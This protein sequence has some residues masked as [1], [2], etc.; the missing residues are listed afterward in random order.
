MLRTASKGSGPEAPAWTPDVEINGLRA[1]ASE[2]ADPGHL[3]ASDEDAGFGAQ[4]LDPTVSRYDQT[5]DPLGWARGRVGLING[6]FDSLETRV[7]A[8]GESYDR[9]RSAFT[10][11]LND[12]WYALLVTTKY[13]G[14][15]TTAR[16][17][18]DDPGGRPP[19]ANVSAETQRAALAF[20]AQAG[21][22][23]QAYRFRPALLNRLA[24]DRWM[25]W[26][27]APGSAGRPDFPLHE[28]A[29]TQQGSLLGQLLDPTVLARIRDAE[30]RAEPGEAALGLPELFH[31][32]TG[33]IWSEIGAGVPG[34]S[35]RPRN[36]T[37]V[38][39]DLQRL[40]LNLLIQLAVTPPAGAP[41]DARALARMTLV[42]LAGDL[43]RALA[44]PR[45]ELDEYTRAHLADGRD[46]IA[47]A[48]DAQMIQ[49]TTITR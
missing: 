49:T 38:R 12:R 1:I 17:H 37:S 7:V 35:V 2:A 22:G 15:A 14:G 48:L 46:R 25:H 26:G 10:D 28:W 39:R 40:E 43:D 36:V 27:A 8:P 30:L 41:E 11:L 44:A 32:L 18:R 33:S 5:D 21:F 20:L 3:Y 23:E 24:T 19:V 34:R 4:G 6:L 29:L 16:D 9:L 47:R 13:L 31:T 42:G 45:T